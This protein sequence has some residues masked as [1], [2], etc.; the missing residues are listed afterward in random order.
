MTSLIKIPFADSE[1]KTAVP[2]TDAGGGVNMTQGYGQAYSLD[3]AT[4]PSAKRIK[5]LLM[6]GLFNL[7]TKAIQEIQIS[8]V[9]PFI[10]TDDNGGSPYSYAKGAIVSLGG[11][12]YQSLT[13]GNTS[14]P[15]GVN[16]TELR[17]TANCLQRTNS[18]GDIKLD[19]ASA[20][21]AALFNPGLKTAAQR[22]VGTGAT[23]IPDIIIFSRTNNSA[24]FPAALH[25]RYGVVAGDGPKSFSTPFSNDCVGIIFSVEDVPTGNSWVFSA[26]YRNGTLSASCFT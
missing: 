14:T 22:D 5:R 25:L 7:I 26:G 21:A 6:N 4:D 10:T 24:S 3:P 12:V 9:A 13:T 19:G 15:P 16:W 17:N 1:D 23:Q 20:I 2:V 8:G 11:S 18:F